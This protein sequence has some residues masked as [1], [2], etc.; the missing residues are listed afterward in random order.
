GATRTEHTLQ[1]LPGTGTYYGATE[2]HITG[3]T[4]PH[5]FARR[6]E[7]DNLLRT[8][9]DIDI[10]NLATTTEWDQHKDLVYSTTD[11]TGLKSTTLYDDDRPITQ[12]GPA[13]AAWYGTDRK[14][15]STY[16][17]DVP[18]TDTNYDEGMQGPSVAYYEYDTVTQSLKGAPKL[19]TTNLSGAAAGDFTKYITGGA[20]PVSGLTSNW[21][22][23]AT[24]KMRLPTT[25]NYTFRVWADNGMRLYIDDKIVLSDW[26][27]SAQRTSR[28]VGFDNVA[29]EVH[30]WRLEYYHRTGDSNIGLYITPPGGIIPTDETNV[31]VNQYFKPD[32][33]LTTSTKVYDATLGN[34]TSTTS[35][36]SNPEY[37]LA[38]STSLDP[39]GLNLTT[40]STYETPGATGSFMRQTSKTLPGGGTTNYTHYGATETRD[41]PCTTSTTEAF[42]QAGFM[43]LKTEADP[44]GAG[45]QT[46]RATE[47][48]YDDTGRVVATRYNTDSWTCTTYDTRGRVAE[49]TVPAYNGNAARTIQNDYAVGGSPLVTTSWDGNGW[50]VVWSDLL[51]RTVKYRDVYD[52]ETTTSYDTL[53]RLTGRSGPL[54]NETLVYDT[55]NRLT[56]QKL[57]GTT[58][59]TVYYDTYSRIDYV[60]YSNANSLRLTYGRDSLGRTN[61]QIY[62]MGNGTTTVS[63]TVNRTQSGQITN[64]I[65]QSGS[66][67]LWYTYGYDGADRLTSLSVGANSFSY[68]FGT[69]NTT[70]CGT[71]N[72]KNP[73]SGK[74]S[75]RTTQTINGVATNFC[76]DYADR[77]IGS[78]DA[79]YNSPTYDTHGNMTQIGTGSTPL[80]LFYD[81]SDRSTGY[82]QYDSSTTGVGMY[83]DRDVQGRI[84]ARYKNTIT[85]G[86]WAS[87]GTSFYHFTGSGDTPDYVRDNS[88][89]IVE[90]NISLPGGVMLT[91][92]PQE[93]V[94]NNQKQ[95]SLPNIHGDT[96]LTTDAA[97]T[98]TSTGNG[99]QNAFTYD[100]FGNALTGSVLPA[101]THNGSYGWVGQHQKITEVDFALKPISMGARVYLPGLGRFTQVDSVEGGVENSYV[102]PADPV[103]E[104]D[105]DGQAMF[106]I[107]LKKVIK[108]VTVAANVAS[109]VPGP[110]GM[111]A[112][113][114]AAVGYASQGNY[115][116][117]AAS[118]V[119]FIP[120]GKMVGA[121]A[122]KSKTVKTAVTKS[123]DAQAKMRGIGAQSKLF[124]I[125]SNTSNGKYRVGWSQGPKGKLNFRMGKP[126]SHKA[127]FGYKFSTTYKFHNVLRGIYK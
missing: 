67:D 41:N 72:N 74:N 18:R 49:T 14:P 88:W 50:I 4:E 1:Y 102:Y 44:D 110:I 62:R 116:A 77:L 124:G 31:G 123:M 103:N 6:V 47:T 25:G 51:G 7:Y 120:G 87:A 83:Y 11:A 63:D 24:G 98:N 106:G 39:T 20:S 86:S 105:L 58:Y 35:Y 127:L 60:D 85:N 46:G 71:G 107:S 32:Y 81:S 79:Q 82:E 118:L 117:A 119:G 73:N 22:I 57:D 3:M 78:S 45:I 36:G 33:N 43:K 10:A 56:Q 109:F 15:T 13:P 26:S 64:N 125:K 59:A 97:G 70:T 21:G 95:Y 121:I 52:D 65:V 42:R 5:G 93:S 2:Q 113:A 108:T 40:S 27:D 112:S 75:N 92:K 94:A 17:N 100:A 38:Q 91:V 101:N 30:R 122:Y 96:L 53:G 126:G 9:K 12:Y 99:P 89:N 66:N 8:V 37:G 29:G 68:G 55:Y 61:S 34:S 76:Y 19:H 48:V 90:K 23:R 104:F 115:A 16:V 80:H 28:Y 69:Q 84:I 114:I 111:A 54:G